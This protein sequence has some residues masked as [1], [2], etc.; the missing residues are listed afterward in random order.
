MLYVPVTY[1]GMDRYLI[2][3]IYGIKV[4]QKKKNL[5]MVCFVMVRIK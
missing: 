2:I 3:A 5:N 1:G 4:N